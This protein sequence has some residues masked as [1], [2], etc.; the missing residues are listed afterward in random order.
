MVGF[1]GS[2]HCLGMCS[3]IAGTVGAS[4]AGTTSSVL[5]RGGYLLLYNLGRISSYT[6]AGFIAAGLGQIGL[7]LLPDAVAHGVA[8]VISVTFLLALGSYLAGW[9]SFLPGLERIGGRLWRIVEPWG[10]SLLPI[11]HWWQAILFGIVWGWLPCGL[12]YSALVWAIAVGEPRQG[13]LLML[14]FGLGTLPTVLVMGLAGQGLQR[15]RA[16]PM[17]R[18]GAGVALLLFAAFMIVLY[19]SNGHRNGHDHSRY[20]TEVSQI[21]TAFHFLSRDDLLKASYSRALIHGCHHPSVCGGRGL[22][23]HRTACFSPPI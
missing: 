7:G 13:A 19:T 16:N 18:R 4:T 2:T 12:V 20:N 22:R 23:D 6:M 9:W 5:G 14:G 17:I 11:R 1:L 10:R 21:Q 3:G 15:L 8:A